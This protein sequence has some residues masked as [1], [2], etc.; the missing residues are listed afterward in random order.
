MAILKAYPKVKLKMGGYTDSRGN[1]AMNKK[2]SAERSR[3]VMDKVVGVGIAASRF[4][5]EGYGA[6]HPVASNDTPEG[7]QQNR[8]VDVRVTAK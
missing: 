6:E 8:R 3:S 7:R 2:L 1:A 4:E 5:S